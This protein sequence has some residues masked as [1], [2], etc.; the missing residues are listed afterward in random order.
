MLLQLPK[1]STFIPGAGND[2]VPQLSMRIVGQQVNSGRQ[3]GFRLLTA[4]GV[5]GSSTAAKPDSLRSN[6]Q[7]SSKPSTVTT[8]TLTAAPTASVV[9]SA[10]EAKE[11]SI[12]MQPVNSP[13]VGSQLRDLLPSLAASLPQSE[14]DKIDSLLRGNSS[15]AAARA[16]EASLP[17]SSARSDPTVFDSF[18]ESRGEEQPLLLPTSPTPSEPITSSTQDWLNAEVRT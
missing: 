17:D 11:K 10:D 16:D 3:T 1:A 15:T 12:E 7:G 18:A 4:S 9:L 8:T 13:S 5:A 14:Q 6:A 2:F